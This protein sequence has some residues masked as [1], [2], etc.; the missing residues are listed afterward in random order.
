MEASKTYLIQVKGFDE[1]IAERIVAPQAQS[2]AML[3]NRK[4]NKWQDWCNEHEV[5]PSYPTA[6]QVAKFLV[7]LF[8][9]KQFQ[10]DTIKGYRS[11]LSSALK[12]HSAINV[13]KDQDI[14]DLIQRLETE[15]PPRSS[16]QPSWDLSFVLWSLTQPPFEPIRDPAKVHLRFLTWK[17]CFLILLASGARRSEIHA[18]KTKNVTYSESEKTLTLK[19][20]P[21]FISKTR[22]AKGG[23]V[24]R[25]YIIK[26]LCSVLP[27]SEETDRSLCPVRVARVYMDRTKDHRKDKKLLF[28]AISPN[29]PT[30]IRVNTISAWMRD[31]IEYCYRNQNDKALELMGPRRAHEI[32][33]KAASVVFT[34]N[35]A[36]E[37]VLAS[38]QWQHHNTFTQHYL[39]DIS[40]EDQDRWMSLGPIVAGGKVINT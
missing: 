15:R 25:P 20:S 39:R 9:V 18:I 17:A 29:H 33:A 34:S 23:G 14:S 12:H 27:P 5:N 19:P 1:S 6:P 40:E 24:L 31:L 38:G 21:D 37:D 22:L 8:D 3:Y 28:I 13:G 32:R 10:I 35:A 26:S 2:T 11:M 30:D 7:Y 16:S 4:W 36:M